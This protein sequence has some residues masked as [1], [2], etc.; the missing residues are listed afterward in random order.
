MALGKQPI[1]IVEVHPGR[2]GQRI[3]GT[4]VIEPNQLRAFVNAHPGAKIVASVA[5]AGPRGEVRNA[6]T[7]MGFSELSDYVCAA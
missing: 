5:R 7:S 3:A 1:L 6:L 4:D 2:I